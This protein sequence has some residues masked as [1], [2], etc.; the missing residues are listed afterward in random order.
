[1]NFLYSNLSFLLVSISFIP[2]LDLKIGFVFIVAFIFLL[3]QK[4]PGVLFLFHRMALTF[5]FKQVLT[6]FFCMN[7]LPIPSLS[8]F[9]LLWKVKPS[10]LHM[11]M[12]SGWNAFLFSQTWQGQDPC[13]GNSLCLVQCY[14]QPSS[15][16]S[17]HSWLTSG[18][19]WYLLG[20]K[21]PCWS[22]WKNVN[23]LEWTLCWKL[24]SGTPNCFISTFLKKN[25]LKKDPS[26][27][28]CFHTLF[29]LAL[30]RL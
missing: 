8:Y 5:D 9:L 17:R 18:G 6:M 24:L 13:S 27:Y 16:P 29:S 2:S 3:N 4:L 11:D 20:L 30:I 23:F 28:N 25:L 1:M 12:C 21:G 10:E 7:F 26:E 22:Q 15:S 14:I 19:L